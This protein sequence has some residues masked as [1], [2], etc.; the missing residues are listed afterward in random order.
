MATIPL[1]YHCSVSLRTLILALFR[2]PRL[3]LRGSLFQALLM[4]GPISVWMCLM[5]GMLQHIQSILLNVHPAKNQTHPN[6]A[7]FPAVK[8]SLILLRAAIVKN[9]QSI[10]TQMEQAV[11]HSTRLFLKMELSICIILQIPIKFAKKEAIS[12]MV[13]SLDQSRIKQKPQINLTSSSTSQT[14]IALKQ[15]GTISTCRRCLTQST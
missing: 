11:K 3:R 10:P 5:A 9:V 1:R 15:T 4:E 2:R 8:D 12:A 7:V 14:K 6:L 13:F